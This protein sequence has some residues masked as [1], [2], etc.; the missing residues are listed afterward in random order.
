MSKKKSAWQGVF[1][2]GVLLFMY[3]PILLMIVFSFNESKTMAKWTGFSLKWYVALFQDPTILKALWVSLAVAFLSSLIATVLGTMGAIGINAMT[4][5]RRAVVMGVSKLPV[6]NPDLV[7]GISL[8]LIFI[9]VKNALEKIGISFQLG[10]GTMLIAHI[11][12]NLPYVILSVMPRLRSS[13][14]TLYEAALD[15][16]AKPTYAL[17]RIIIPDIMPG[18][19]TG[20]ILAFTLSLDDFVVTFFTRQGIQNLSTVIYATVRRGI[21]P[22]INALSAI[23]FV[24][25]LVLLLFVNM[26]DTKEQKQRKIQ[27][28]KN[29]GH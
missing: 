26:R 4:R 17:W 9:F 24:S 1:L 6:F 29:K 11:T 7:T 15:L 27:K 22:K 25:V 18:I 5:K 8:M 21:S 19:V 23:M 12:F 3:A 20:A 16:G 10:F 13:S 14:N 28:S 2:A